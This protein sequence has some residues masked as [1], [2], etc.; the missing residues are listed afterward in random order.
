METTVQ[1]MIYIL[2]LAREQTAGARWISL[3]LATTDV[4][5]APEGAPRGSASIRFLPEA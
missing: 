3:G 5:C 4:A 1:I 2:V